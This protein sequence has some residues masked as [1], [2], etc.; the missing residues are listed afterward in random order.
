ML[1]DMLFPLS[2]E[3]IELESFTPSTALVP[4]MR[5]VFAYADPRVKRL[6][7]A[8]KYKKSAHAIDI[9][10]YALANALSNTHVEAII[11][12][13]P[14]TARRRR[15][16]GFDQC[17]LL[18]DSVQKSLQ[19]H[20][21]ENSAT[22]NVTVRKDILV[23]TAHASRQTLKN[24]AARIESAHGI[25]KAHMTFSG[26]TPIIVIDDVITTGSTMNEAIDALKNAGYENVTGLS[27]AH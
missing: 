15:E 23:R 1:I 19:K 22:V 3:E 27:V 8:I 17:D 10:G 24:R 2:P 25:F 9:A 12:P 5:A 18:V 7:W 26:Q 6:I 4:N 21:G 20:A 14:M 13:L 16:R 11:I